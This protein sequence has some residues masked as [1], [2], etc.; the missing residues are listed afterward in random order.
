MLISFLFVSSKLISAR[1]FPLDDSIDGVSGSGL[2]EVVGCIVLHEDLA[3]L[4]L[5]YGF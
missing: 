3:S 5:L 1:K 4:S 2:L